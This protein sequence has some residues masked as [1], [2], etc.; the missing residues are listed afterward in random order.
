MCQV[1]NFERKGK[2]KIK[3]KRQHESGFEPDHNQDAGNKRKTVK[4]DNIR[5][6]AFFLGL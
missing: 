4:H 5:D 2:K 1:V 6:H 3:L